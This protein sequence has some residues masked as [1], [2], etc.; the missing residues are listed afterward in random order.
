MPSFRI[1]IIILVSLVTLFAAM[2][3]REFFISNLSSYQAQIEGLPTKAKV[4]NVYKN[5][6]TSLDS[7]RIDTFTMEI[8]SVLK[9][10]HKIE[11]AGE[12]YSRD[13]QRFSIGIVI[14]MVI[15]TGSIFL[16][17][18]MLITRPLARL[19]IATEQLQTGDFEIQVKESAYSPLNS[20]ILSFNN[21]VSEL[22]QSREKLL[23]AEKQTIWREM[24][25]AMAHEI[26][27]PLTP[28]RLAAQRL[29]AKH[30]EHAENL[31]EVLEKSMGVINEE[32]DNLQALVNAFS[33]FAKMPEAKFVSYDLNK[34]LKEI[35]DQYSDDARIELKLDGELEPI[36]ADT[37]QMKQVLVN[38]IQN[39]IQACPGEPHI[40]L[41]TGVHEQKIVIKIMDHGH[42]I[43]ETDL[44]KIFEPYFTTKKKGTG[45]GLAIVRRIIRQHGGDIQVSSAL[46]KG[47][48]FEISLPYKQAKDVL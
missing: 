40:E 45:L 23:E 25:R 21:M 47:S 5:Y 3:M 35:S 10:L 41:S 12:F 46:E 14:L 16:F 42:G 39:A 33:G 30:H 28:I 9:D 17:L 44:A 27:N 29:E 2:L 24:A 6:I 31:S 43:S 1:Q 15:L 4:R 32:V 8:E 22:N 11:I 7:S 48:T 38:L 37:M 19:L 26:K 36:L 34:Q 20:L 18:F 13:I